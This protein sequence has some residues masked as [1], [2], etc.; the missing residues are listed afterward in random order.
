MEELKHQLE[1]E[2]R[3]SRRRSS[4]LF[5]MLLVAIA[6]WAGPALSRTMVPYVFSPNTPARASEINANFAALA[7]AIDDQAAILNMRIDA[8]EARNSSLVPAGTIAFFATSVCP[9]GWTYFS[10]ATGRFIVG[11]STIRTVGG[12]VGEAMTDLEE[13]THRHSI[14]HRH[15]WSSFNSANRIWQSYTSSAAG[16]A[17]SVLVNWG[18]GIGNN[19]GRFPLE[20][21]EGSGSLYTGD[22]SIQESGEA[23]TGT[24]APYLQ[25]LACQKD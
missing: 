22:P 1:E 16:S 11:T 9:I 15:E 14:A 12:T 2:R 10:P 3:R 17:R 18:S 24:I 20:Y 6:G 19:S 23:G 8:V 5:A 13:R 4:V 7:S 21:T 25:L